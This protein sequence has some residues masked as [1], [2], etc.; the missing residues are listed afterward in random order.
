VRRLVSMSVW[1]TN[2]K[3]LRGVRENAELM[4]RIYPGWELV[5]WTDAATRPFVTAPGAT[6]LVEENLGGIHGM[7]WRYFPLGWEGVNAILFRDADSRIN[8]REAAAVQEWLAGPRQF[9]AMHDHPAHTVPLMGG[10][11]GARGGGGLPSIRRLV[12]RWSRWEAYG[13]D[14]R[15]LESVLWPLVSD[16][17]FVHGPDHHRFPAHAT[18]TGFVGEVFE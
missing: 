8:P 4:P 1:G 13:D 15:F 18:Y 5:V 9:H 10:M 12:E 6:I 3:Y 17:V 16:S 14:Q 2:Q 11:W 7:F